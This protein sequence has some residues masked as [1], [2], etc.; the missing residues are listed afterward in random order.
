MTQ[1]DYAI[2]FACLNQIEYTKQC[3]DSLIAGGIDLARVCVVDNGS[4]DGT[5]EYLQTLPFGAVIL[6]KQNLGCGTAWNQGALA[7]QAEWTVVMNNDVICPPGWLENLITAAE[8]HNL[9]VACPSL[10]EGPLDYDFANFSA[11]A[12]VKM[13]DVVRVGEAHGVCMLVHALVW[14]K[15]GYYYTVPRLLG[16]EDFLFFSDISAAGLRM[17]TV[18]ASWLH[19]Y[20]SITQKAMKMDAAF[21]GKGLGDNRLMKKLLGQN[22]LMR[23]LNKIKRKREMR[24]SAREELAQY[25]MSLRGERIDGKTHWY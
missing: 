21:S 20:G 25:G 22:W 24:R 4:T 5:R 14:Q 19:H 18:G 7:L 11:D 9:Q 2:T 8:R 3:V 1:R 15:S 13:R 10:I 17:G 12:M 23:K 16:Y 6:N